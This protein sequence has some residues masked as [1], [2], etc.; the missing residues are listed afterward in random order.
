M[1]S[2][3]VWTKE[4][5]LEPICIYELPRDL[6]QPAHAVQRRINE[7][8]LALDGGGTEHQ[9]RRSATENI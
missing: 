9:C 5:T 1:A 7:H 8:M 6:G 2:K 4:K 3:K